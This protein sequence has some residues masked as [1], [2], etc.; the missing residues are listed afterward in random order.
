MSQG[1]EIGSS[2]A[3]IEISN[4][5]LL[6]IALVRVHGRHRSADP[7]AVACFSLALDQQLSQVRPHRQHVGPF[8][9]CC[10]GAQLD[11]RHRSLQLH[12]APAQL[13]QLISPKPRRQNDT[14][15]QGMPRLDHVE[16]SHELILVQRTPLPA[17]L[18]DRV[19]HG[20]IRDRICGHPLPADCPATE[21]PQRLQIV[22]LR[23]RSHTN[24]I[25]SRLLRMAHRSRSGFT[26]PNEAVRIDVTQQ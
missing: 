10:L 1:V 26:P 14:I 2:A 22:I 9:F 6:Q 16:Q 21:A 7:I 18:P 24:D 4:S 13:P 17:Q 23:A 19:H 12:I 25:G 15:R 5:C 20:N 11:E 8:A 3:V